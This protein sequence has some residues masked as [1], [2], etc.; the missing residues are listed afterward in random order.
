MEKI[1]KP[2]I[3]HFGV[4][5][6]VAIATLSMSRLAAK[7]IDT[8]GASSMEVG[9]P[10]PQLHLRTLQGSP[11]DPAIFANKIT[12]LIYT[13]ENCPISAKYQSRISALAESYASDQRV[14]IVEINGD[15]A[16][17]HITSGQVRESV[18]K[19]NPNH[20]VYIDIAGQ[21]AH[22]YGLSVTPTCYIIGIDGC[23]RYTGSF[24]DNAD[25]SKVS[26]QY[27]ADALSRLLDGRPVECTATQPFGCHVN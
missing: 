16:R 10:A 13:S 9:Y 26:R 3:A 17:T 22:D 6:T 2:W 18:G 11:V 1:G 8:W 5:A 23:L 12:V 24:D 15:P 21:F 27:V 7:T 4:V 14:R 19:R 25:P 20:P